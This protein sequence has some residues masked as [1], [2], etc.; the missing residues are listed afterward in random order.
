[1]TICILGGTPSPSVAGP[2]AVVAFS[3]FTLTF[4]P[5]SRA[6]THFGTQAIN[7][8]VSHCDWGYEARDCKI[9]IVD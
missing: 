3:N 6:S 1:M 4:D 9:A 2:Q 8:V 7:G 5:K